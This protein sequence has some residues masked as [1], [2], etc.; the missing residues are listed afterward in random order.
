MCE[1]V[2]CDLRPSAPCVRLA[3]VCVALSRP[4]LSCAGRIYIPVYGRLIYRGTSDG[5]TAGGEYRPSASTPML[6]P[7]GSGASSRARLNGGESHVQ[8]PPAGNDT[9]LAYTREEYAVPSHGADA[10]SPTREAEVC[11]RDDDQ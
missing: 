8:H 2:A 10:R 4:L 7:I 5:W 11:S 1:L 3:S 6:R 9:E